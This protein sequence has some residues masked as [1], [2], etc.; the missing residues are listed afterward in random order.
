MTEKE[1]IS[2]YRGPPEPKPEPRVV[3]PQQPPLPEKTRKKIK[4]PSNWGEIRNAVLE[5]ERF[6]CQRCRATPPPSALH[7]HHKS[8]DLEKINYLNNYELLC[9]ECHL[10]EAH[11]LEEIQIPRPLFDPK[12]FK[13]YWKKR[14]RGR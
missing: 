14:G 4:Y 7:V 3:I 12:L 5:R 11:E 2:K 9:D 10:F 1:L 6:T 8:Y 13:D